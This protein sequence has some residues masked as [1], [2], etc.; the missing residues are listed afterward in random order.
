[1]HTKRKGLQQT[2]LKQSYLISGFQK[3]F[4]SYQRFCT[5]IHINEDKKYILE[6]TIVLESNVWIQR[7]KVSNL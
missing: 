1:M 5:S 2:V 4:V 7:I 3:S 6:R